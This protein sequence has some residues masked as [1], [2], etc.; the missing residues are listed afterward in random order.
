[1]TRQSKMDGC[2]TSEPGDPVEPESLI[3]CGEKI[4]RGQTTLK[5]TQSYAK[6][7]VVAV[8]DWLP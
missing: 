6:L 4:G 2:A 7:P 8:P 3:L 1:M 5:A